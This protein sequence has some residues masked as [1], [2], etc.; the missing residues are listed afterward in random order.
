M[1]QLSIFYAK[2]AIVN[3]IT[4]VSDRKKEVKRKILFEHIKNSIET[5]LRISTYLL[6]NLNAKY[7]LASLDIKKFLKQ[8]RHPVDPKGIRGKFGTIKIT[9][10]L[11]DAGFVDLTAHVGTKSLPL[12]PL[13]SIVSKSCEFSFIKEKYIDGVNKRK[14]SKP[15][16]F[17]FIIL[18]KGKP[19]ILIETNFFSTSG[20][21]T[22]IGINE[23]E[24]TDLH[25]DI[26]KF[27]KS[28]KSKLSFTWIT[29]GNYWLSKN[30]ETRFLNL[31]GNFFKGEFELL[32]YNLLKEVLPKIK[33]YLQS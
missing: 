15:K 3:Y 21:G 26:Q 1:D 29:D 9:K 31:K 8:K 13:P 2:R 23:G 18:Y 32:N 22:K 17:D 33:Q 28:H 7:M 10:T 14:D 4:K 27:N 24:Y 20:G 11:K 12:E 16:R 30:G 25:E 5:R 19:K 6:E